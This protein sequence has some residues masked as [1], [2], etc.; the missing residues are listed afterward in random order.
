M[1]AV[2]IEKPGVM[3]FREV[4]KPVP[5]KGF[6]LVKIKAAAVC[7]TDLEVIDG[8]IPAKYP[9]IPGHEWS[10]IVEA[11][12]DNKD[13]HWVGKSVIGSNDVVCLTCDH[14]RSG[15]WRYCS[16]FEEIGFRRNGAYAEYAVF[17]VY[18]LC[19]KADNV[20]FE[21]AALC[22]PLGV[23]LETFKKANAKFVLD[24]AYKVTAWYNGH[25]TELSA[26]DGYY[27]VNLDSGEGVFITL[28]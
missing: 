8:K 27:T 26:E 23:A 20:S 19:E 10:G 25:P 24:K 17:P 7:A 15:E 1:K 28:E 22:E 14:C 18:G 11:V 2:V 5:E 21:E 13:A 16:E 9:L 4:S 3:D 6:A 12:G